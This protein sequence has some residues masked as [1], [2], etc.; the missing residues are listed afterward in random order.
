MLSLDSWLD[1]ILSFADGPGSYSSPSWIKL[2]FPN[3]TCGHQICFVKLINQCLHL[4]EDIEPNVKVQYLIVHV[5]K[6]DMDENI[7]KLSQTSS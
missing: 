7:H 5:H 2:C 4:E 1:F 6:T 3:K